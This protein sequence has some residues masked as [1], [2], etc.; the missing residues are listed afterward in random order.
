MVALRTF[1]MLNEQ[2][3]METPLAGVGFE[4][5]LLEGR[6]ASGLGCGWIV[7]VRLGP[8]P[9]GSPRQAM[10]SPPPALRKSPGREG[11]IP[12]MNTEACLGYSVMP[13]Q[14]S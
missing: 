4:V 13:Y 14:S 1:Q 10:Q 8:S 5:R 11:R 9:D 3:K 2:S 7:G 12:T 6:K